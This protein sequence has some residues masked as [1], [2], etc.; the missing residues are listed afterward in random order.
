[1]KRKICAMILCGVLTL[2]MFASGCGAKDSSDKNES[3]SSSASEENKGD[4]TAKGEVYEITYANVGSA[5]G[6]TTSGL[7]VLK[8]NYQRCPWK[9][10]D[11]MHLL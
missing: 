4:D 9:N 1:M 7:H 6:L 3:Q 11:M 10:L 8:K 5:G 2:S